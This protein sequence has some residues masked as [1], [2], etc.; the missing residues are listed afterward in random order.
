MQLHISF[1]L[2]SWAKL[3]FS[4]GGRRR[5]GRKYFRCQILP[6][7]NYRP[8]AKEVKTKLMN[9]DTGA[10][11]LITWKDYLFT[12]LNKNVKSQLCTADSKNSLRVDGV[13]TVGN[14]LDVKFCPDA[15]THFI[16]ISK[17]GQTRILFGWTASERSE[18]F[19]MSNFARMQL[20]TSS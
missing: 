19:Q 7:C 1:Q 6:G 13:G 18:I 20:Q 10:N 5:N 2:V 11:R 3:E 8:Q 9:L 4:S 14:I 12:V 16:S 17:L 15:T